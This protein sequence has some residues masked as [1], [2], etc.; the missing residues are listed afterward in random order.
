[1]NH[2]FF[3]RNA[4]F[5]GRLN[6]VVLSAHMVLKSSGG[7]DC[8]SWFT[9]LVIRTFTILDLETTEYVLRI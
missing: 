1:M 2:G 5:V 8:V 4:D 7:T 9:G 3:F 6:Q